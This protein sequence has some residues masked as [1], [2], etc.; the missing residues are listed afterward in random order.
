[1]NQ[2]HSIYKL[3]SH[4]DLIFY[5]LSMILGEKNDA[6]KNK[7]NEDPKR[8]VET[9]KT[10]SPITTFQ[11]KNKQSRENHIIVEEQAQRISTNMSA[12]L[13]TLH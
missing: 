2:N 1:M 8:H 5:N 10:S 12:N 13:E 6:T 7:E 11:N 9:A 3:S 4:D